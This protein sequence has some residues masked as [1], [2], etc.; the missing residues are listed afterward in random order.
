MATAN[1]E[2]NNIKVFPSSS[3]GKNG[4]KLIN[5]ESFLTTEFNLTTLVR[6]LNK[7]SVHGEEK[8]FVIKSSA[9]S[10]D[11]SLCGYWFEIICPNTFTNVGDTNVGE[12]LASKFES[13]PNSI[14]AIITLKNDVP[15][16]YDDVY[17]E[18]LSAENSTDSDNINSALD[19]SE[20]KFLGVTFADN[21]SNLESNQ[22]SLLLYELKDGVYIVPA[23]SLTSIS[24]N[25]ILDYTS[26]LPIS[27]HLTLQ[28]LDVTNCLKFTVEGNVLFSLDNNENNYYIDVNTADFTIKS[29]D[30]T[31]ET[32]SNS[33]K[34]LDYDDVI[35]NSDLN[36]KGN[37]KV[38]DNELSAYLNNSWKKISVYGGVSNSLL[39]QI[40]WDNSRFV[41]D[42]KIPYIFNSTITNNG[43]ITNKG[44][45]KN[46][47]SIQ[48]STG[49]TA[50]TTGIALDRKRSNLITESPD[51]SFTGHSDLINIP[52]SNINCY[53]LNVTTVQADSITATEEINAPK[54]TANGTITADSFN[55]TSDARLKENLSTFKYEKS[56]LDLPTYEYNFKG[57]KQ[58]TI[59][60][61]AQDLLQLYPNLVHLGKD[62]F[63]SIEE[64]KLIYLLKEE[65][66]KLKEEI[67]T[68]KEEVENIKRK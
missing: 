65:V 51:V 17:F 13:K 23:S 29:G 11:F 16:G 30:S 15:S 37:L 14:Y 45:I 38:T 58:R 34:T 52:N 39:E 41:K 9:S 64:N 2:S 27:E 4:D 28:D 21:D 1:I 20:G 40:R 31:L 49:I 42:I 68:L 57:Q 46:E 59:G 32:I 19:D 22:Y 10:L 56:I 36:V 8:G 62:G 54:I 26:K 33:S 25:Y 12:Y 7:S 35:V 5:P 6:R 61:L 50:T 44:T 3:R 66:R 63:Y 47:S 67:T 53:T 60:I 55:A 24:S 18:V 48:L 43:T